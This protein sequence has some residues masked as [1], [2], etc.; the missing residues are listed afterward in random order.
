MYS[1]PSRWSSSCWTARDNRPLSVQ[2]DLPAM[3][4]LGNNP[5]LLLTGHVGDVAGDR[6]AALEVIVVAARL[7]DRGLTS[8][9]SWLSTSTTHA[10][11]ATPTCGAARPTP[12][13]CAH[14]VGQIIKQLMQILAEAVDGLALQP[15]PWVA[16]SDDRSQGHGRSI[17]C[18]AAS[19]QRGAVRGGSR[20]RHR[21]TTAR[22]DRRREQRAVHRRG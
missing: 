10:W 7:D 21:S 13:A 18:E 2:L 12:G 17:S 6:Q 16:E 11:S 15:Q 9:C 3:A 20:D 5:D 4:V 1:L 22:P 19:F 14:G 8:S